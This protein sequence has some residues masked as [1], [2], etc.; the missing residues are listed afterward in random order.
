M[1]QQKRRTKNAKAMNI[2][3]NSEAEKEQR[4]R[5]TTDQEAKEEAKAKGT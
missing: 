3:K 5:K 4:S 2:A 1:P